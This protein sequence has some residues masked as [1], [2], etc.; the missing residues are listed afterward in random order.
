MPGSWMS[1]LV[2][3]HGSNATTSTE[4]DNIAGRKVEV[5]L[6]MI[7]AGSGVLLKTKESDEKRMVLTCYV[8]TIASS[9]GSDV[10]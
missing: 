1:W 8:L 10:P 5:K 7:K 4:S 6:E 9:P 3:S 2:P